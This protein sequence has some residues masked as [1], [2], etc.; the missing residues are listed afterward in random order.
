MSSKRSIHHALRSLTSAFVVSTACSIRALSESRVQE[1]SVVCGLSATI[2]V[3]NKN[4]VWVHYNAFPCD[5]TSASCCTKQLL[6]YLIT[7]LDCGLDCW[8]GKGHQK[9]WQ[10]YKNCCAIE[11]A[12]VNTIL[13]S[14]YQAITHS[15]VEYVKTAWSSRGLG[16]DY[17]DN[18]VYDFMIKRSNLDSPG[19]KLALWFIVHEFVRWAGPP[20]PTSTLHPADIIHMVGVSGPPPLSPL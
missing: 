15:L 4:A 11:N 20:P 14:C 3:L 2:F 6:L 8:T 18:Y 10:R 1:I 12:G 17:G 9:Y 13:V 7:G 5:L 19:K 16:I